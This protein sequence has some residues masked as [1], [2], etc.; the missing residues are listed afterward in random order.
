MNDGQ[1]RG[2]P[3]KVGAVALGGDIRQEIAPSAMRKGS[4]KAFPQVRGYFERRAQT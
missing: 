4:K 2:G 3:S 1:S